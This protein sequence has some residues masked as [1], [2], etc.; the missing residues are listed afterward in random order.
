MSGRKYPGT[1]FADI[2][3]A[4]FLIFHGDDSDPAAL[5]TNFGFA[6]ADTTCQRGQKTGGI[7]IPLNA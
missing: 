7:T 3:G 2:F 4:S 6:G 5:A 1:S